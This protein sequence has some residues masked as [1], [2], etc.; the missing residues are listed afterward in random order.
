VCLGAVLCGVVWCGVVW[1]G[2]VWCGVVWCVGSVG[3]TRLG[4]HGVWGIV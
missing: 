1:C 2:V 4:V 3:M